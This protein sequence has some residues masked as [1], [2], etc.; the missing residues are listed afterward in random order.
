MQGEGDRLITQVEAARL[1]GVAPGTVCRLVS[2]GLLRSVEVKGGTGGGSRR[3]DFGTSRRLL[4]SEVRAFDQKYPKINKLRGWYKPKKSPPIKSDGVYTDWI[5][6]AG[7]I[8]QKEA[9]SL[10]GLSQAA[11]TKLAARGIIPS[12]TDPNGI[13]RLPRPGIEA[14][15]AGGCPRPTMF[16]RER[17]GPGLTPKEAAAEIGLHV[18]GIYIAIKS[19]GLKATRHGGRWAIDPAEFGR[20]RDARE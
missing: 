11:I 1:L 17:P 19:G 15:V 6:E 12:E 3:R 8:S 18:A 13:R 7:F 20:F 5:K 4:L 10:S 2:R 16:H 14:W 9:G